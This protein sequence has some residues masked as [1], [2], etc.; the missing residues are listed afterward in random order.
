M[1]SSFKNLQLSSKNINRSEQR[2][3][4]PRE[5]EISRVN[6]PPTRSSNK[7]SSHW[8]QRH[9]GDTALS[10][11]PFFDNI[12]RG[13]TTLWCVKNQ[14]PQVFKLDQSQP[15][16]AKTGR[17]SPRRFKAPTT[18]YY[19]PCQVMLNPKDDLLLPRGIHE[20]HDYEREGLP[21]KEVVA[22]QE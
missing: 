16:A 19:L 9:V 13:D 17:P 2:K 4:V 6:H 14:G 8:V 1:L 7:L 3:M 20:G 11:P 5:S 12:T 15:G 22:I 18:G 21:K 10:A